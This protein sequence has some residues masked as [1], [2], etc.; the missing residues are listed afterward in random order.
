MVTKE[1]AE[2]SQLSRITHLELHRETAVT[3]NFLGLVPSPLF[4]NTATT[5]ETVS[6]RAYYEIKGLGKE[7]VV[8]YIRLTTVTIYSW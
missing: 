1:Q 8:A 7:V 3:G 5:L 6:L 4:S 2:C